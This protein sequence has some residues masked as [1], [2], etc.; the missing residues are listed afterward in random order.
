MQVCDPAE[1]DLTFLDP[2]VSKIDL[3]PR[4]TTPTMSS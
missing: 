1:E 3:R 2:S 4:F